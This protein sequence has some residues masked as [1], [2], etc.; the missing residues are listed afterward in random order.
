MHEII[1]GSLVIS[2]SGRTFIVGDILDDA[3]GKWVVPEGADD[4]TWWFPIENVKLVDIKT[5][6]KT[7][8]NEYD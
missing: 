1:K 8:P 5:L 6:P 3:T 7:F 2:N 4:Y